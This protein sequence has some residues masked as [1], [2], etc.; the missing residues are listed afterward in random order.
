MKKSERSRVH[1]KQRRLLETKEIADITEQLPIPDRLKSKL[2]KASILRLAITFMRLKHCVGEDKNAKWA[3]GMMGNGSEAK[4]LL[5]TLGGFFIMVSANMEVLYVSENIEKHMGVKQVDMI[6]SSFTDYVF[7]KDQAEVLKQ[8]DLQPVRSGDV[9]HGFGLIGD[10]AGNP[11]EMDITY[12]S[13]QAGS[14]HP[15]YESRRRFF[16]HMKCIYSQRNALSPMSANSEYMLLQCIGYLH[17][18]SS[19]APNFLAAVCR[20]L[21]PTPIM[22][23]RMD[24]SMFLSRHSLDMRF[25]YCDPRLSTIF[26]Y[27]PD[28]VLGQSMYNYHH[29]GDLVTCSDCHSNVMTT[30]A[31]MS[32]YYRFLGKSNEW[33]WLQTRATVVYNASKFPQYIVCMNYIV[34][35]KEGKRYLE[36][37]LKQSSTKVLEAVPP[38]ATRCTPDRCSSAT[39]DIGTAAVPGATASHS[40][41]TSGVSSAGSSELTSR[42]TSSPFIVLINDIDR[43][44]SMMSLTS[45]VSDLTLCNMDLLE[46]EPSR[47]R[48]STTAVIGGSQQQPHF[49]IDTRGEPGELQ[50]GCPKPSSSIPT[51]DR[52]VSTDDPLG[53]LWL[54]VHAIADPMA[55]PIH[56]SEL[57]PTQ[58]AEELEDMSY[59]HCNR[60]MRESTEAALRAYSVDDDEGSSAS[61][62]HGR[63]GTS[64]AAVGA[65]SSREWEACLAALDRQANRLYSAM[66]G[67]G[68][69]PSRRSQSSASLAGMSST[70]SQAYSEGGRASVVSSTGTTAWSSSSSHH[71][72]GSRQQSSNATPMSAMAPRSPLDATSAAVVPGAAAH[73]SMHSLA[74]SEGFSP[75]L[76]SSTSAGPKYVPVHAGCDELASYS[77]DLA[78]DR[79]WSAHAGDGAGGSLSPEE[80]HAID[81]MLTDY[82]DLLAATGTQSPPVDS[83]ADPPS[84]LDIFL[85]LPPSL[86]YVMGSSPS[87]AAQ[88]QWPAFAQVEYPRDMSVDAPPS[89]PPS[90][91]RG[92]THDAARA[93]QPGLAVGPPSLRPSIL[94]HLLLGGG[95]ADHV[96]ARGDHVTARG[97]HCANDAD[98]VQ[99]PQVHM[100]P[101]ATTTTSNTSATVSSTSNPA[102]T[103]SLD[104]P[105]AMLPWNAMS[106]VQLYDPDEDE[107]EYV[108]W[109]DEDSKLQ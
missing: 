8:F 47:S 88:Q 18:T 3:T 77:A 67:D 71:S 37:H 56:T 63:S 40:G 83:V 84:P 92:L 21:Q 32:K 13:C 30:G 16:I 104:D 51:A 57:Y 78:M 65:G 62:G 94:E 10:A 68:F 79:H 39:A 98:T 24:G 96:T 27:E 106:G 82:P 12:A 52:D 36:D 50:S 46:D 69:K 19:L 80:M 6:S 7:A 81:E 72:D 109:Y 74:A 107:Q 49:Y 60:L 54:S 2:D 101:A 102:A 91:G 45:N 22:E 35:E 1:A 4:L 20:P 90:A 66:H 73:P 85:G 14:Q 95:R 28:E 64:A 61:A 5:E 23:L 100:G 11:V 33:F 89:L 25:I 105:A 86:D 26:G 99:R 38:S 29:P 87:L 75:S 93:E 58:F 43:D 103:T 48:S 42:S 108:V 31:S 41:T 44:S 17:L 9:V 55:S 53:N 97:D 59:A 76:Q 15:R 70:A 34:S